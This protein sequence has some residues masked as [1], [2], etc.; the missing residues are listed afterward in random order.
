MPKAL[1]GKS[2]VWQ[3]IEVIAGPL[4]IL[5]EKSWRTGELLEDWR[6]ASVTPVFKKGK[7]EDLGNYRLVSLTSIPGKMMGWLVLGVISKHMEEQKAISSQH[8]LT[9]RKSCLTNLIAFYDGMTGWI[10]EG[11]ACPP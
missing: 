9:K 5:F 1:G 10:D 8:G 6:K 7:K 11:R 3:V 2:Q 4:S